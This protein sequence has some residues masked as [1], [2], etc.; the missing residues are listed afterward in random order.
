MI[1][2]DL[3]STANGNG[4]SNLKAEDAAQFIKLPDVSLHPVR[5][6]QLLTIAKTASY[7]TGS[8][9]FLIKLK[10]EQAQH[11]AMEQASL[12]ERRSRPSR[13]SLNIVVVGAGLGG[14]AAAIALARRGHKVTVVEQAP[15]LAEVRLPLWALHKTHPKA[16]C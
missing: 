11:E 7:P 14:L 5:D 8:L 1:Q 9:D 6:R 3:D 16:A 15:F 10:K 4:T 2:S 12:L 13:L